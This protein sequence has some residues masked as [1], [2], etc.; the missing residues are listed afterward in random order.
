ME[1]ILEPTCLI[2]L[3]TAAFHER[4]KRSLGQQ[5]SLCSKLQKLNMTKKIN[6]PHEVIRVK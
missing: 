3:V 2:E 1:V 6:F 5:S 4:T